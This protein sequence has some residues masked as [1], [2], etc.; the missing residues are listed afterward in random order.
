MTRRRRLVLAASLVAVN[1]AAG[2]TAAP[3]PDDGRVSTVAS[4]YPL[5]FAL[6]RI[7]GGVVS[8]TS[9]TKPG[10]EPHDI[11]PSPRQIAALSLADFAVYVKGFQ[12]HVDEAVAATTDPG[13]V[14]DVAPAARMAALGS[15]SADAGDGATAHPDGGSGHADHA[16]G[17][18]QTDQGGVHDE[19][20]EHDHAEHDDREH[21]EGAPDPHFWL[22]PQRYAEVVETIGA[23]LAK[24][25]PAHRAAYAANT[26]ALVRELHDLDAQFKTG[27]AH[28]TNRTIV[29]SHAAFGYLAQRYGFTQVGVTGISPDA[30]PTPQRL[31]AVARF[32]ERHDV[33]TIYAETLVSPRT[34]QAV[35]AHTGARVAVLDPV[36]GITDASEGAD[37]LAVMRSN[38]ATLKKGQGC[39]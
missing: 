1:A 28:C 3:V 9:L 31:A 5:Q 39:S 29:T 21:G 37:Y 7:G 8:V 6:Q 15:R 13:A 18:E 25:D 19:H 12:T 38:L 22:D 35:A 2:C 16:H 17:D 24:A 36:E 23:G 30:E 32:V 4:F 11:D 10:Q 20:G 33:T 26:R 14:L 27:L 34:A